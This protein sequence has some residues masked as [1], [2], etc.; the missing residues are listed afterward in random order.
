MINLRKLPSQ[1]GEVSVMHRGRRGL[2]IRSLKEE[3]D[4]KL[5]NR[6]KCKYP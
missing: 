2:S 6:E 4:S 3:W 1:Y 5:I